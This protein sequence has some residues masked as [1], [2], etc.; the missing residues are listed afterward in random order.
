M[1]PQVDKNNRKQKGGRVRCVCTQ[2]GATLL[3]HPSRIAKYEHQFCDTKCHG[4]WRTGNIAGDKHPSWRGGCVACECAQC[5]TT[6]W[7]EPNNIAG[8]K[9]RFCAGG[10]CYAAWRREHQVGK[11]HHSWKG[12]PV[13][14]QCSECGAELLRGASIAARQKRHFC[15]NVCQGIWRGKHGTGENSTRWKGGLA[16]CQCAECGTV[17][18]R[19]PSRIAASAHQ[20]CSHQKCYA[21][22]KRKHTRGAN[23]PNWEGGATTERG[24][25]E[26]TEGREW[27]RVCRKRDGYVCQRCQRV[28]GKHSEGLHV[29]HKASF[30][31]YP[32][33]RSEEA[34]GI[35]LCGSCHHWMHSNEGR[36]VRY[37]WEQDALAELG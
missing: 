27:K 4:A 13:I 20:F 5:G 22:W 28:F 7:R 12:G 26:Q 8:T 36:L 19:P 32:K 23:S 33:L 17:L 3:R 16:R 34:N 25:W 15:N 18:M 30:A 24:I 35:C 29:H 1:C 11:N 9:R 21:T 6:I 10:K 37:R 31:G 14:C 2:C